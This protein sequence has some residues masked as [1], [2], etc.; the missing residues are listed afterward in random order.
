M[1]GGRAVYT[2]AMSAVSN[3]SIQDCLVPELYL[4]EFHFTKIVLNLE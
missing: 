1:D 3:T 2:E 4:N